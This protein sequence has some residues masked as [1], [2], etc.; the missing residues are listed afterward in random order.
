MSYGNSQMK[1]SYKTLAGSVVEDPQTAHF[2]LHSKEAINTLIYDIT[3]LQRKLP[4]GSYAYFIYEI[5]K[6]ASWRK[7]HSKAISLD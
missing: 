1:P 7:T 3:V 4:Y 5:N 6:I 2:T